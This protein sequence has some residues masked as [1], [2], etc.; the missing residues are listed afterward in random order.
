MM[1]KRRFDAHEPEL[2]DR[3]DASPEELA[4]ALGS[5]RGLNRYFG[6]HRV[7]MKFL[8]RWL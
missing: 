1:M 6:S 7:V 2:M 8:K 3:P 5:L 4:A